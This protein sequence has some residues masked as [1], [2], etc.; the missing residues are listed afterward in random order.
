RLSSIEPQELTAGIIRLAANDP[1]L[2]RHFHIPLQSGDDRILSAMRRPY[3]T[4]LVQRLIQKI[5]AAVPDVCIG[6]DVMV[7]FP[8]E[9]DESF[10]RTVDFVQEL[11]PS[12]LHVFPFSPRPGTRAASFTPRVPEKTAGQRVER[13][14]EL[15]RGFQREFH[16]RFLGRQ[17]PAVLE[18]EP[19]PNSGTVKVRTDNY[20]PVQVNTSGTC[21][22]SGI[23]TVTITEIAGEE[24]LGS[25]I[26]Q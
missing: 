2:C 20:I 6:M 17:L 4:V 25:I 23:F 22:C 5:Y 13:L 11:A 14:R 10:A 18:S 15:S 3:R 26:E 21:H 7:G 9:D 1:G 8:G 19:S 16:A 24:V 12:Y